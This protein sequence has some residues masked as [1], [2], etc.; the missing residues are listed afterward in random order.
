MLI[1]NARIAS[2]SIDGPRADVRIAD[3]RITAIGALSPLP[4]ESILE[5]KGGALLPGLHDHHIHLAASAAAVHSVPCGPP[6]VDDAATLQRVLRAAPGSDWLRGTGYDEAVAGMLSRHQLDAWLPTRPVRIQHRT[7]RMWFLN[8]AALAQLLE[9]AAPPPGLERIDGNW[10]GRL[11]DEDSW[12]RTTLAASPP[13]LTALGARLTAGGITGVTDMSPANA[14]D[15]VAWLHAART[16][17]FA[18]AIM[19]AGTPGLS[20]VPLPPGLTLGP[21]KLHLHENALPDLDAV[22][23]TARAAHARGRAVA[24]H[25]TTEVELVF[26][27][28]LLRSAGP[29]PGDRIEH[30]GIAPDPL[31]AQIAELGLQVVSQ[32]AFIA[33]R[34]DRYRADVPASDWPHLYRLRAFR[35]A[36]VTLAAGSDAPYGTLDPW[37]AMRAACSR[38]TRAGK[39]LGLDERLSPE[40]ALDLFLADPADLA[41]RRR[42]TVGAPADLCLLDRPWQVA[43]K[44]LDAAMV[45]ATLIAGRLVHERIDTRVGKA[46]GERCLHANAA[47]G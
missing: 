33:E 38:Q 13:D 32:P 42:I 34:G 37:A 22:T 18:P 17:G 41:R 46:P 23:Q 35:E 5:A 15:T 7:G 2:G 8:S 21:V 29:R 4:G 45:R 6:E 47:A 27:L 25:C 10:T 12:L 44:V 28:A 30:A 1:R 36:G 11:F 31:I 39:V 40:E 26:A 14:R 20:D 24:I 16:A 19:V 9:R 3:G 43:R